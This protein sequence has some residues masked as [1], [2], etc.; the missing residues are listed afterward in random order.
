MNESTY[1]ARAQL[2]LWLLRRSKGRDSLEY[3]QARAS[4]KHDLHNAHRD[5][6]RRGKSNRN[7]SGNRRWRKYEA[8]APRVVFSTAFY[9]LTA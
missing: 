9:E 1:L 3:R 8:T 4:I 7:G 5:T 6:K 2:R